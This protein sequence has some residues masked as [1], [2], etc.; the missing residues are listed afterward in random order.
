MLILMLDYTNFFDKKPLYK[1]PRATEAKKLRNWWGYTPCL[2]NFSIA[3][4]KNRQ[5][6]IKFGPKMAENG[7][8]EET[9]K[10]FL[11]L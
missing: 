11:A 7:D 9:V 2:R 4:Q 5:L 8:N 3:K 10:K 1:K 6:F